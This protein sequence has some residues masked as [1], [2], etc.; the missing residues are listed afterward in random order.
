MTGQELTSNLVIN[1]LGD[2]NDSEVEGLNDDEE[3]PLQRPLDPT[4]NAIPTAPSPIPPLRL[5]L[6]R[7]V[8]QNRVEVRRS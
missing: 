6:R 5:R 1:L 4:A 8:G 3:L 7:S 2:G